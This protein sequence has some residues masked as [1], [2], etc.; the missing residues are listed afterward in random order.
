MLGRFAHRGRIPGPSAAD[1]AACARAVAA[2]DMTA[3]RGLPIGHLSGVNSS[4]RGMP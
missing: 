2:T 3:L 1:G 4:A